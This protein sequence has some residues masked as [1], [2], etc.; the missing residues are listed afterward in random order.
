M[1][2]VHG[3]MLSLIHSYLGPMH[4]NILG[5]MLS[6]LERYMHAGTALAIPRHRAGPLG[7][8]DASPGEHFWRQVPAMQWQ[9]Q[10][11]HW[12]HGLHGAAAHAGRTACLKTDP[13][14]IQHAL[15]VSSLQAA[16]RWVSFTGGCAYH[17]YIVVIFLR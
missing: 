10:G 15:K 14:P 7:C 9:L 3:C 6:D 8:G 12:G 16:I 1:Y 4:A 5:M 13:Y 17:S 11:C 2:A